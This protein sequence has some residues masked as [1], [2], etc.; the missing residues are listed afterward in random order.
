VI[1]AQRTNSLSTELP[2]KLD[3]DISSFIDGIVYNWI[4][5]DPRLNASSD[6]LSKLLANAKILKESLTGAKMLKS[7][8]TTLHS[9]KMTKSSAPH[10]KRNLTK[11]DVEEARALVLLAQK[12]ASERNAKRVNNPRRNQYYLKNTGNFAMKARAEDVELYAINSTIAT[13]AA[14]V[15]EADAAAQANNGT[16]LRD[17]TIPDKY[18]KYESSKAP[19]ARHL[20]KRAASFWMENIAHVG[21]FPYGP[22]GSTYTVFR[23]VKDY[24]AVG[25]GK[26]DDTAAI[27]KTISDGNRCGGKCGSSSFKGALVYFP[28]GKYSALVCV[29]F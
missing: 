1:S 5:T 10:F 28:S 3:V 12:E 13:A 2:H 21:Y 24:G 22:N 23:N 6:A 16:L 11:S 20:K 25:D 17:Y 7:S 18:A 8:E 29:Q 27:N 4:Q 19:E 14:L 9:R 15:A 26:T